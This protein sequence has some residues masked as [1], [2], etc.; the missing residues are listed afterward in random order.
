[1][2]PKEYGKGLVKLGKLLQDDKATMSELV[3]A[4]HAIN[5]RIH[6][7]LEHLIKEDGQ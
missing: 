6:F 3:E 1:M 2:E 4:A 5:I 7:G